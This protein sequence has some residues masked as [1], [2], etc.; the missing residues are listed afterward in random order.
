[1]WSQPPARPFDSAQDERHLP[2]MDS[3]S[4]AGMTGGGGVFLGLG[5]G[6]EEGSG[7][8]LPLPSEADD[9]TG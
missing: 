5:G 4:G 8:T 3:G 9:V 2:G 7:S 1:M 6:E